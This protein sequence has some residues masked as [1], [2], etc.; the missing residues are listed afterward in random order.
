MS[1]E[2]QYVMT[3]GTLGHKCIVHRN[4]LIGVCSQAQKDALSKAQQRQ[5]AVLSGLLQ[6]SDESE[7]DADVAEGGVGATTDDN[8]QRPD[9]DA[10][11][12]VAQTNQSRRPRDQVLTSSMKQ[13]NESISKFPVGEGVQSRSP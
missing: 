6:V 7:A 11:V 2:V 13:S 8:I 12:N 10:D 5:E 3:E 9:W 1:Y 4:R